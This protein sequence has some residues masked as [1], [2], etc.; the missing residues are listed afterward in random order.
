GGARATNEA[1]PNELAGTRDRDVL[2]I[3]AG[4]L[5]VADVFDGNR[6]AHDPTERFFT[7]ALFASGA[8]DYPADTRGYTWGILADLAIDWWSL[9]A[10]IALEPKVAN[11]Q[12]MDWRI[13]KAHG[14]MAE[15]EVRYTLDQL[16]G[17]V[18]L[19]LFFN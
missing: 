14:L 4:R 15:Y 13:L 1:G 3:S 5:S 9:R 10:G 11:E 19:L 6:Y 12:E 2:A 18:S 7:W 16:P 17:G 8:W